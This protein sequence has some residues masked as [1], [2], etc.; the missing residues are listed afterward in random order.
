MSQ[1]FISCKES[2]IEN[3]RSF[4]GCFQ[5]GPF[6]PSQS[7]T[8][9]NT[10]RRTLLSELYGLS[11]ISI[12]IEGVTHEYSNLRGVKDSVLDILLNIKE[13]V[14]KKTINTIGIKPQIGYLKMRGPGVVRASNL[15]L[16]P[17]VQSVDP[18]QY[19]ATL[20]N[21]GFLNM[22]FVI[23]YSNK[24]L[25]TT[26]QKSFQ[27][28]AWNDT[29]LTP[30]GGGKVPGEI[31][32]APAAGSNL[33]LNV[34]SR[35]NSL[36]PEHSTMQAQ[37]NELKT[38]SLITHKGAAMP[39]Q[40]SSKENIS[41]SFSKKPN[42]DYSF[43]D[44]G[45]QT[46][47]EAN[48]LRTITD[49]N[50]IFNSH[51]K[52]RRLILKKLK[53]IGLKSSLSNSYINL[54]SKLIYKQSKKLTN[55][56]YPA[57]ITPLSA[58]SVAA[59]S[60]LDH[61][62]SEKIKSEELNISSNIQKTSRWLVYV[63]VPSIKLLKIKKIGKILFEQSK[64]LEIEKRKKIVI[65]INYLMKK[66]SKKYPSLNLAYRNLSKKKII[67]N[68]N[69]F[70][71]NPFLGSVATI[72]T[73]QIF[74]NSN[75]LIIDAIFNPVT[76]VNYLIEVNDFKMT[77]HFLES[78]LEIS[79]LFE[80]LNISKSNLKLENSTQP[81]SSSIYNK[82]SK[83]LETLLSLKH[84]INLL[85]K[86]TP[87]HNIILEIWTNGSLHPRDAVY[88]AFKNLFKTFSKLNKVNTFMVNPLI[89]KSLK[90]NDF[91]KK[92]HLPSS[93]EVN[94]KK[95][96]DKTLFDNS[97]K[98]E[99]KEKVISK[100][101]YFKKI[102]QNEIMPIVTDQLSL[103]NYSSNLLALN[104]TNFLSTYMS[105]KLKNYYL[106]FNNLKSLTNCSENISRQTKN[107]PESYKRFSMP[108]A[109]TIISEEIQ[110]K[111][112]TDEKTN[113]KNKS[114]TQFENP[115]L[116]TLDFKSVYSDFK[117]NQNLKKKDFDCLQIN[118]L[119]L[120]LRS[121]TYLK[122]LNIHTVS[123]LI[124]FLKSLSAVPPSKNL[125]DPFTLPEH[126]MQ[127]FD[128]T[129]NNH[130]IKLNKFCLEEIKES[131]KNLNL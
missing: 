114:L 105:P 51:L 67:N 20:T 130:Y 129:I 62:A 111:N 55:Q 42:V 95:E 17:L 113:S 99:N 25:S 89:L 45:M 46:S 2:R 107:S 92:N 120:S 64:C 110:V 31:M 18:D 103:N 7:I 14:L 59:E 74:Y 49:Y 9:A 96:A 79:E 54:F 32:K 52:K 58:G 131:L 127:T 108:A 40:Q 116:D 29:A 50:N 5:L 71:Q 60:K 41:N 78:S 23:Q 126:T 27:S 19:I 33:L 43:T 47:R 117:I 69:S 61:V 91:L 36:Q 35:E 86:E 38:E 63:Q 24:W 115:Q 109:P 4:Y 12:E 68:T 34:N 70:K 57:N 73:H 15:I 30:L 13:I 118:S 121:Y 72:Q 39:I 75:P 87:K 10:L 124:L 93:R 122:R 16:P 6:E 104:E 94:K 53:Q 85:K 81:I 56:L 48:N 90:D 21:D 83:F 11:I 125:R 100:D 8:I 128:K 3:N 44:A 102:K 22:K 84:E 98:N 28:P 112:L 119:N 123:D 77:Q 80:I 101:Y 88:Q 66:Y 65:T 37:L 82:N 97:Y 26:S 1:F 76:K 106:N